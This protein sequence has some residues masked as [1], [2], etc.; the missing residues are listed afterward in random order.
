MDDIYCD[1]FLIYTEQHLS[2]T[3]FGIFMSMV[4]FFHDISTLFHRS[5][6]QLAEQISE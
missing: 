3:E 1:L 5:T 4:L 2:E 6:E